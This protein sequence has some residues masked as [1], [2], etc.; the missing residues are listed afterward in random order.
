MPIYQIYGTLE[1]AGLISL[2]NVYSTCDVGFPIMQVSITDENQILV[3]GGNLNE[4]IIHDDRG[5]FYTGDCGK[6]LQDGQLQIFG[7]ENKNDQEFT[8]I[9][10]FF[11]NN[12]DYV[13]CVHVERS[14]YADNNQVDIYFLINEKDNQNQDIAVWINRFNNNWREYHFQINDFKII[15]QLNTFNDKCRDSLGKLEKNWFQ[16]FL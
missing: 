3:K 6:L 10:F 12:I 9:E 16:E 4:E 1:T 2:G 11:K 15:N 7:P 13:E 14:I 5:W 8:K